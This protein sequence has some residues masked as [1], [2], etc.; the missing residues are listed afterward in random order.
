[1]PKVAAELGGAQTILP[2]GDV[3]K[4]LKN[5]VTGAMKS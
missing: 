4:F 3:E 5:N 1:M 2:I